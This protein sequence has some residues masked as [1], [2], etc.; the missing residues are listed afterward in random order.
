[1]SNRL[2]GKVAIVTGGGQGYGEEIV[3]KFVREGAKVVLAD[4]VDSQGT[5]VA[6]EV[7]C[8]FVHM[9]VSQRSDWQNLLDTTIGLHGRLDVI[10]NNAGY[11]YNP[12]PAEEVTD[13][14]FERVFSVNV[15]S[16]YLSAAVI[17]PYL[18]NQGEPAVF[19]SVASA[20]ARRPRPGLTWY[21]ASK[22]AIVNGVNAMALEYA[23]K[24]IRFNTINPAAGLTGMYVAES[25][26][27]TP[28]RAFCLIELTS[29]G[30]WIS[31]LSLRP[32]LLS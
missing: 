28:L 22:A 14:E 15:K 16:N 17:L 1:M 8:T 11:C 30:P 9:D 13:A 31:S 7:G 29:P 21:G 24:K 20:S 10:V 19:L 5:K 27:G 12:K 2:Q 25:F 3:R 26:P 23:P 4:I 18:L 32:K 6:G